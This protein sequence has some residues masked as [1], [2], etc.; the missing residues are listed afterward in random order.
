MPSAPATITEGC[1]RSCLTPTPQ[2]VGLPIPI[3]SLWSHPQPGHAPLAFYAVV[4]VFLAI[5]SSPSCIIVFLL[6]HRHQAQ[7]YSSSCDNHE[8]QSYD[9]HHL[10]H[11]LLLSM[12]WWFLNMMTSLAIKQHGRFTSWESSL[13]TLWKLCTSWMLHCHPHQP[14]T[15]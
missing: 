13:P 9:S 11:Q 15:S 14:C 7:F 3:M 8:L 2:R 6:F 4:T 12:T 5:S 10:A 1:Y